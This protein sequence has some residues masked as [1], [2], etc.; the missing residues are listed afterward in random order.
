M[1]TETRSAPLAAYRQFQTDDLDE[2]RDLVARNFCGHRLERQ[3]VRDDF[4]ACQHRAEGQGLSYNYIR[5]GA[6]VEIEPGELGSFYLIQIPIAGHAE[7]R[8]GIDVVETGT[9]VASVLNPHRH[10]AMRWHAGCEQV[11][12]QIDRDR[13][14]DVAERIACTSLQ[15]PVRFQAQ[16]DCR[17][18]EMRGWLRKFRSAVSAV[19]KGGLLRSENRLSQAVVEDEL[20]AG[21]LYSQPSNIAPLLDQPRLT[22]PSP[23]VKRAQQFMRAHLEDA[24]TITD[25]AG[26]VGTSPRNLQLAFRECLEMT[27]LEYLRLLRLNRARFLLQEAPPHETIAQIA[28][29]SGFGHLSRF[30]AQYTARFGETPSQTRK[31]RVLN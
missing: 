18:E 29:E 6:D 2:A 15:S 7:I 20:I 27:P 23:Y 11:L 12:L 4:D 16:I 21:F 26:A 19:D 13:L 31:R 28:G 3:S 24:V 30:S 22:A 5:Y 17:S 8:N 1:R 14:H 9:G 10:T 25:V